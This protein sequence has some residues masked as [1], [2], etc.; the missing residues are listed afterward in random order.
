MK[1]LTI[2]SLTSLLFTATSHAIEIKDCQTVKNQSTEDPTLTLECEFNLKLESDLSKAITEKKREI[3]QSLYVLL[4][5]K[6]EMKTVE[7]KS[8]GFSQDYREEIQQM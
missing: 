5:S 3:S 2:L 8:E 1:F 6:S 4:Y 7:T